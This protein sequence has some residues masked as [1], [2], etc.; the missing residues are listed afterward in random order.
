MKTVPFT[1]LFSG[2]INVSTNI[3]PDCTVFQPRQKWES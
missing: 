2:S 3:V 1:I